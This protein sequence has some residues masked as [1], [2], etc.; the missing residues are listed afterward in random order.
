[1]IVYYYYNRRQ[2]RDGGGGRAPLPR[3]GNQPNPDRGRR[4]SGPQLTRSIFLYFLFTVLVR[5]IYNQV[6]EYT[7]RAGVAQILRLFSNK[8]Q[9]TYKC[10][11]TFFF[12]CFSLIRY[13]LRNIFFKYNYFLRWTSLI[14]YFRTPVENICRPLPFTLSRTD[15]LAAGGVAP[16]PRIAHR[17]SD[18]IAASLASLRSLFIFG[19]RKK[20]SGLR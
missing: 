15:A 17:K 7:V 14:Y 5:G 19:Y 18:S 10:T 12:F 1:M 8:V 11:M 2:L 9:S 6:Y 13:I 3:V 16:S 20:K 4:I